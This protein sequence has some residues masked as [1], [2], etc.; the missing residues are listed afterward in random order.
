MILNTFKKFYFKKPKKIKKEM[1]SNSCLF[2]YFPFFLYVIVY[3][4]LFITEFHFFKKKKIGLMHKFIFFSIQ[5]IP[6]PPSQ[7]A[8]PNYRPNPKSVMGLV[9]AQISTHPLIQPNSP[10][11]LLLYQR[12]STVSSSQ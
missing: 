12:L 4:Y 1:K 2:S 6:G 10:V 5:A 3:I 11:I 7:S 8:R 9:L